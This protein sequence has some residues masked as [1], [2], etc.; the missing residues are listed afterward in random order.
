MDTTLGII[1][2]AAAFVF[3]W[4]GGC[5]WVTWQWVNCGYKSMDMKVYQI[6]GNHLFKVDYLGI[7]RKKVI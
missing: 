4:F 3:G 7:E 1:L 5:K 2:V 6:D